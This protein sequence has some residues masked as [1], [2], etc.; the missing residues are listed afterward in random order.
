MA[1]RARSGERC[2]FGATDYGGVRSGLISR[3][4]PR[5]SSLHSERVTGEGIPVISPVKRSLSGA[6][7]SVRPLKTHSSLN[8]ASTIPTKAAIVSCGAVITHSYSPN[9][10][11]Y[12]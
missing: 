6:R 12:Y 4:R 5:D 3:E 7:K 8:C 9:S 11:G 10:A 2:G 1:E